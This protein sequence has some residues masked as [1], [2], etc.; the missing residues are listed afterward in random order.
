MLGRGPG[1]NGVNCYVY[2]AGNLYNLDSD[3]VIK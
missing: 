2:Q 1:N 3:G